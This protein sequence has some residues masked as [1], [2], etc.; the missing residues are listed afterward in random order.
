MTKL[1]EIL[2]E[3]LPSD[4]F[5]DTEVT[6][7][8]L[9]SADSRYGLI[10]RAIASGD[11]I[12]LRRGVYSLGKRYQRDPPNLH[13]LAQR[14]YSPS[15][16]SLETALS[17]HGWIPEA[18]YTVTSVC[19]KRSTEFETAFGIFSYTRI[20]RFTFV[21]VDRV[22]QGRSVYLMATPIKAL[23]DYVCVHKVGDMSARELAA[24]LRIEEE[25]LR[26]TSRGMLLQIMNSYRS[27]RVTRFAK[28]FMQEVWI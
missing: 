25:S 12:Q 3:K 22:I 26:S 6:S 5:T 9:G 24:S 11:I 15:Y 27:K 19:A 21:G 1:V 10:K 13:E 7:I 17:H 23:I 14:I 20:P 18:A 2:R 28:S 16:I 4:T 8:L